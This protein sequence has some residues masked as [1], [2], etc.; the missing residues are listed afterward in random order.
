MKYFEILFCSPRFP[1]RETGG[2]CFSASSSYNFDGRCCQMSCPTD[3]GFICNVKRSLFLFH[4]IVCLQF[5]FIWTLT[6][7]K[8][9]FRKA[10]WLCL[11]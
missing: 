4:E 3:T 10:S 9:V 7:F 2:W 1:C 11:S 8:L 6:F 5:M